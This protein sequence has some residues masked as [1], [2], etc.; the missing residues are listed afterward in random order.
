M[1]VCRRPGKGRE[2]AA[3]SVQPIVEDRQ[4]SSCSGERGA[5]AGRHSRGEGETEFLTFTCVPVYQA[6]C[7]FSAGLGSGLTIPLT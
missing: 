2:P 7:L 4:I 1:C 5:D 3:V 6:A